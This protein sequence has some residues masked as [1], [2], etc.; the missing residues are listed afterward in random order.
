MAYRANALPVARTDDAGE[1][2]AILQLAAYA[3]RVKRLVM[4]PGVV[5]GLGSAAL[6][7]L[8]LREV[9]LSMFHVHFPWLSA[10]ASAPFLAAWLRVAQRAG[11]RLVQRRAPGWIEELSAL[12]RVPTA[13]LAEY[14]DLL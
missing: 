1:H 5:L 2:A 9:Q 7:F 14:Q 13:T 10:V 3:A 4:V 8:V 11:Q 6:A 12:Y